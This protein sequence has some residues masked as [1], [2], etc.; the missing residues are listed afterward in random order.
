LRETPGPILAEAVIAQA[1]EIGYEQIRLDTVE[2][3]MKDALALY[4]TL[5]FREIAPYRSNRLAGTLYMEL[6]L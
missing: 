1:R 4:R 2:P 6:H 3:V 5:G